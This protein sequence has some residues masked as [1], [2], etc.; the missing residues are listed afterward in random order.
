MHTIVK[1]GNREVDVVET[2][3]GPTVLKGVVLNLG[4][5][6]GRHGTRELHVLNAD[7]NLRVY[8][9]YVEELVVG[10][11]DV[12]MVLSVDQRCVAADICACEY[13]IVPNLVV[14]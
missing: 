13:V 9:D 11:G 3:L 8:P 5:C 4:D 10:E 7:R 12:A 6:L 1:E 14:C 2:R